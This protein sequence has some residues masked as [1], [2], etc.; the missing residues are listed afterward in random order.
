MLN[1]LK[2]LLT[3]LKNSEILAIDIDSDA[4]RAVIVKKQG[5]GIVVEKAVEI[6]CRQSSSAV[7]EKK[8]LEN[9][10]GEFESYPKKTILVS[11]EVE[12]LSSELPFSPHVKI[13]SDKLQEAV[14]WEAEPY[15]NFTSSEGFFR[16]QLLSNSYVNGGINA[17]PAFI[18]AISKENYNH[19]NRICQRNRLRLQRVYARD[20][21][22]AYAVYRLPRNADYPLIFHLGKDTVSAA[23]IKEG[24][25]VSFQDS[26]C[27]SM[28]PFISEITGS[29]GLADEIIITGKNGTPDPRS[30]YGRQTSFSEY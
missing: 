4:L 28:E 25:P 24:S 18:S 11:S 8:S 23:I 12:F 14:K 3:P 29:N 27:E 10:L 13:S 2:K 19:F 21:A 6:Q 1:K 20:S 30:E 5:K 7:F 9:L 16:Y 17:T 22:F 15:L 26:P